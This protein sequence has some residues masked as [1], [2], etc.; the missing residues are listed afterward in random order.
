MAI[1][2]SNL[3]G[4]LDE[5]LFK[6]IESATTLCKLRG[7]P[8][9]ELVHWL[10]QLW[11]QGENDFRL[12][13]RHFEV[14]AEVMESGFTQSLARLPAG[15]STLSD[16]SYH[17]ELAIERAWIYASLE[18]YDSR[19][20]S[21]HLLIAMLTT[22]E[23]RRALFA[24]SPAFERISLEH[25]T[26]DFGYITQNSPEVSESA[27]DG[28]VPGEASN[29][30]SVEKREGGLN[31][32]ATDL[33]ALA[34]E[35]KIDPVTGRD[36]EISTMTDILL[37]RR[38]NNPL[39]TGEAGVG[40]TA[41]VEGLALEIVAGNVPPALAKV[42]LLALDVVA[43]SAG[44]SMKGEFEAR[45]KSVLEEA[46]ASPQPVILFIDEVHTLVGAGGTAGTGDAANLLKPALARGQLRTIGATT[47][48]EFKRHIEKDPALTRRF[49]VLQVTEPDE[50][51]AAC[52]LRSLLPVLE[53]HHQV[54]ITDE[55]LQAAVRLS[56]RYIPARQLPDK[57]ISL[58]DTACA[59]VAVAQHTPPAELQIL[60]FQM[61][62]AQTELA[63]TEKALHLGKGKKGDA[64]SLIERI[65]QQT[66]KFQQLDGRWQ[67]EKTQVAAIMAVREELQSLAQ[68][69]SPEEKS[70]LQLQNK[71]AG[72]EADLQ[73]LRGEQPL[74]HAE[75]NAE[76][77]GS[78]V[79]DWTGIPVG[80]M[81]K[82]DIRAVLELPQRLAERVIGQDH[83]LRQVSE[84][85]QTA[86]AGLADPCKPIGVFMLAGPSGV[87]K[88]ETALAIAEQLYGGEHN[89]ITLNMSEY[90]EA[91]T[92][93]SLKGSPPGYVGYG[94]GGVLTEAVRRK[95]YSVVLLDEI[96]KAHPDVHELFFQVFDKG[97]M[98]DGEGRQID[99]KNTILLLTSNAGSELIATLCA[100]ADTAP[101]ADGLKKMLQSELLK[102]FPA[103][104]LGR[105]AVV[106]YLPL[107]QAS[108]QY[109][110]RL[111]LN[112]IGER[113]QQQ[114]AASLYYSDALVKHIVDQCP[115]AETGARMLIRFIEQN[116]APEM[117]RRILAGELETAGRT[118]YLECDEEERIN[119]VFRNK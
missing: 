57:A 79:A 18:C 20:R 58:L 55:A 19:I 65:A 113:L 32:Y 77:I 16:F 95:P 28:A 78:I 47:W 88:T 116:I 10:N 76:V 96:E 17:I 48:R 53:K 107:Q 3:F 105:T 75:V 25:L 37:R 115:V 6:S 21:G 80:Q 26:H 89:L 111:H 71:L 91:H 73:T 42:R 31:Q 35:G 40:K 72:L 51:T 13:A 1:T 38:Q 56:H 110:V 92:V 39:L 59:R 112:K 99:F 30:L 74:V 4:K 69:G 66:A 29:A 8:Y 63:L 7:N 36:R 67:S 118:V 86:R 70:V 101:E 44:A 43:L 46:I 103:A 23:L 64:D 97:R 109:I 52:M 108:L 90:Q 93:S 24:I 15:A 87:G 45:L 62:T 85:I 14:D 106:P 100:D 117:G 33:T 84:S 81:L 34:R 83:A 9:V 82:D 2:R 102:T 41:V 98:E 50:E 114:H 61:E 27:Q 5:T 94:E 119:I 12:I 22:M 68:Q 60:K 49:Q 11:G 104:F 54:W